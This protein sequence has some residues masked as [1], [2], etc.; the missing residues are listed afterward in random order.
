MDNLTT[1]EPTEETENGVDTQNTPI[2][3]VSA[4]P[5]IIQD[6]PSNVDYTEH[7]QTIILNQERGL[8]YAETTA[9]Y[10]KACAYI[11]CIALFFSWLIQFMDSR[12]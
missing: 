1:P 3:E 4:T 11:L 7:L 12:R 9:V 6:T 5:I 2:P 10:A 8:E